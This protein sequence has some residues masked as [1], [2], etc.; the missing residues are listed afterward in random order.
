MEVNHRFRCRD[1]RDNLA[2][3]AVIDLVIFFAIMIVASGILIKFYAPASDSD[4]SVR[5][6]LHSD[7]AANL[8]ETVLRT[9]IKDSYYNT[10]SGS[11]VHLRDK[12]ISELLVEDCALR[13]SGEAKKT[14]LESGMERKIVSILKNL[15]QPDYGFNLSAYILDD[16]NIPKYDDDHGFCKTSGNEVGD[17]YASQSEM[18]L[19]ASSDKVLVVLKVWIR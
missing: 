1:E 6:S 3:S 8:L 2:Q 17:I 13:Q 16:H 11:T 9:T 7:Y 15:T 4:Y 18:P 10:T 5:K 19:T 14:S 12:S